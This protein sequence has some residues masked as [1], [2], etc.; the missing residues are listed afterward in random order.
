MNSPRSQ[1]RGRRGRGRRGDE[2]Q[3]LAEMAIVL[4][5]LLLLVFGII[6]MSNAW[7]TF[8]VLTN[9]AREGARVGILQS[10]D[11]EAIRSRIQLS[12]ESGGIAYVEDQVTIEC[13][14]LDGTPTGNAVCSG[15][16]QEVRIRVTQ[17]F[18]YD[19]L[20]VF[21][22]LAPITIASTTSMRRE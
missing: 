14:G 3:A 5:L 17:P 11:E 4:P 18:T 9:A 22:G 20:G 8:Q 21:G 15:S 16:G 12:L 6:E 10:A 19:V 7:R 13:I 2:G 1:L